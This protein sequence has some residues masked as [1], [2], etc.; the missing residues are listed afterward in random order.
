LRYTRDMS[1]YRADL[2]TPYRRL[3]VILTGTFFLH[4]MV[5]FAL[6]CKIPSL[7]KKY[8][9][10]RAHSLYT[11]MLDVAL[12]RSN[13]ESHY[14]N[15]HTH[16]TNRQ[17]AN[18]G[19][20]NRLS[21]PHNKKHIENY[22]IRWQSYVESFGNQY[23]PLDNL[24]TNQVGRLRLSVMIGTQGEI[25]NIVLLHSSGSHALDEAAMQIVKKAAPF[26]ALPLEISRTT[27]TLT[28]TRTWQFNGKNR[29]MGT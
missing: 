10:S 4:L 17:A 22:I 8:S 24:A 3:Q 15:N 20:H 18:T 12:L 14:D 16:N 28:I 5:L 27:K 23:Y 6:E 26:E 1:Y 2:K 11:Q 7:I 13:Y 9:P 29:I 19:I 21:E 25:Q